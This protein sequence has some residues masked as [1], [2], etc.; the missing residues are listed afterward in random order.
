MLLRIE[1]WLLSLALTSRFVEMQLGGGV[2]GF[3]EGKKTEWN[4]FSK[5]VSDFWVGLT[6]RWGD[7]ETPSKRLGARMA[8]RGSHRPFE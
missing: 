1:S 6:G 4:W 7:R 3:L 2:F 8:I 5:P